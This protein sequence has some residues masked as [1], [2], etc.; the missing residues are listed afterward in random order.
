MA[1]DRRLLASPQYL[2]L[3][4]SGFH[5]LYPVLEC[6]ASYTSIAQQLGVCLN[7]KVGLCERYKPARDQVQEI[8][9][10]HGLVTLEAEDELRIQ[11]ERSAQQTKLSAEGKT[12]GDNE[13]IQDVMVIA[14]E[15]TSVDPNRF[16][17]FSLSS[18]SVW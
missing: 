8:I 5:G 12:E 1:W 6:D 13:T 11:A 7:F 4:I 14:E 16:D 9:R 10:K 17:R 18:S 2:T 15:C 3:L